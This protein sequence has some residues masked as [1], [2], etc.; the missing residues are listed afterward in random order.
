[1]HE[2]TNKSNDTWYMEN[3]RN[4]TS[5]KWPHD[6]HE[7]GLNYKI[8]DSQNTPYNNNNNNNNTLDF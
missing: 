1:M 7:T 5:E 6:N 2:T 3:N 8:K 4:K